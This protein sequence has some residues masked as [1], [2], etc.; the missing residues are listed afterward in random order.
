VTN[1]LFVLI[2]CNH[3]NG[4]GI[5]DKIKVDYVEAAWLEGENIYHLER[6]Q[7]PIAKVRPEVME[8][9]LYKNA[10]RLLKIKE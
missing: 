7:R 9:Y 3:A 2:P 6:G 5:V 4:M 1:L 8:N 10:A